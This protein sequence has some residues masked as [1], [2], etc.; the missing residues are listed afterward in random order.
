[1]S[2]MF[3]ICGRIAFPP[4]GCADPDQTA[5]RRV[6]AL[7]QHQRV[8]LIEDLIGG[9]QAVGNVTVDKCRHHCRALEQAVHYVDSGLL[10][11]HP[12]TDVVR[13]RTHIGSV[14]GA[15]QEVE[16]AADAPTSG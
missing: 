12:G 13:Y 9:P 10:R 15:D 8:D 1:M 3:S 6:L 5:L 2:S 16:E 4:S 11:R 14:V 7:A